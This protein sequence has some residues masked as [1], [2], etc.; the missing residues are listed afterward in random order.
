MAL[1]PK[2]QKFTTAS[3][4]LINFNATDV[5]NGLGTDIFYAAA[6]ESSTGNTYLLTSQTFPGGNTGVG[7]FGDAAVLAGAAI[8]ELDFDLAPFNSPRTVKG[9]ARCSFTIYAYA[10]VARCKL[11]LKKWDG[12]SETNI[13]SQITTVNEAIGRNELIELPLTETLFAEGDV[14]RLS[15]D[16][17]ATNSS[18]GMGVD[19][20]GAAEGPSSQTMNPFILSVQFKID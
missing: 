1:D 7:D 10:Q 12:S 11:Q 8:A 5:A 3:P 20:S 16:F 15:I 18:Q 9:T 19:P 14:L 17:D 2:L 6:S 4:V 13:S